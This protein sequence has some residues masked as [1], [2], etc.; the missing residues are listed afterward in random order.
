M[1]D[2]VHLLN[3]INLAL[4]DV[5]LKPFLSLLND[6]KRAFKSKRWWFSFRQ[7]VKSKCL[8]VIGRFIQSNWLDTSSQVFGFCNDWLILEVKLEFALLLI[9]TFKITTDRL[10]F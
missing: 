8:K 2:L 5:M 1:L 7:L 9:V 6:Y 10:W 4:T 3:L